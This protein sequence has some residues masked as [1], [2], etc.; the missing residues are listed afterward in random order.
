MSSDSKR[1]AIVTGASRG[2]GKGVAE[3]LAR[4]GAEVLLVGR[5]PDLL[6]RNVDAI[7]AE[8]AAAWFLTA[9]VRNADETNQVVEKA[10]ERWGR[11]DMLVNNAGVIEEATSFLDLT[12]EDWDR[13][14]DTNLKG[15]FLIGQRVA[16]E[17]AAAGSGAIVHIASID[18]LGA[19]GPY[20]AYPSSKAGI[21]GL[22]RSMAVELAASGVRVN[23]VSPGFVDTEMMQQEMSPALMRYMRETFERIPMRRMVSVDEVA[24]CCAFLLS[25][26]ASGVTGQNL[27]VD[28]GTTANLYIVETLP[29]DS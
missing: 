1:T 10:M 18:G 3:R 16:R 27:I 22:N 7:A 4:D 5:T 8:G 25:A 9:D 24:A 11:I 26:D 20:A 15:Y 6:A 29:A 17:M 13:V 12:E 19:D 2:I 14:I 23:A 21:L 28:C